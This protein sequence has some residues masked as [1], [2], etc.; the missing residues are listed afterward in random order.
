M[1]I[2]ESAL[3][4][5]IQGMKTYRPELT[6]ERIRQIVQDCLQR[7]GNGDPN[8]YDPL[9]ETSE[10]VWWAYLRAAGLRR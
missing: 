2:D 9:A 10:G 8:K 1:Q 5:V 4:S 6:T 3:Q 7:T